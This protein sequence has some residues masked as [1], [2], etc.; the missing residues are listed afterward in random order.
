MNDALTT[1]REEAARLGFDVIGVTSGRPVED[2]LARLEDWSADGFG[3]DLGY[4]TRNPPERATPTTLMKTTRT[5]ISVA[6]NHY[7]PAPAFV[8]EGRYGRVA[9]YAWGQDYH[10]V[11]LPRLRELA[12]VLADRLGGKG[13]AACD[14]SPILERAFAARAGIGF[15][16]K[17]TCLLLPRKGSWYFLGEVLLEAELPTTEPEAQDHCGTCRD[18]LPACPTDALVDPFRLDARRCISYL[19]IEHRGAIPRALRSAMGAWLFGCDDCQEV[20]PFNRFAEAT[21]WPELHPE[22]GVGQRLDVAELLSLSDDEA[23]ATRF[24]GTPLSR[25]GRRGLL[26]NAAVVA[27]NVG[28]ETA[29][30]ALEALLADPEPLLREHALWALAGLAPERARAAAERLRGD[31]DP[32]VQAE[33]VAILTEW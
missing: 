14:H 13:R 15:V 24:A 30:P 25:P 21:T 33:A 5:V 10:D 22:Q 29:I 31:G 6:V 28:A 7:V 26:R 1:V 16:G 3:G 12:R 20:C 27:R 18:C 2:A 4:M 8:D 11:V 19:T 32:G 9:R 17:N 23:F